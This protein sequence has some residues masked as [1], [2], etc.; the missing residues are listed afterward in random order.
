MEPMNAARQLAYLAVRGR[1]EEAL[2]LA[3]RM[4]TLPLYGA[5]DPRDGMY[6]SLVGAPEYEALL[7]RSRD[8]VD[9]ERKRLGLGALRREGTR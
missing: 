1:R 3:A 2:R 5:P 8:A 6:A 9:A 4:P 7:T